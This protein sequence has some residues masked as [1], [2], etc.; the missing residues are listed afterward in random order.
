MVVP[1]SEVVH[2]YG[3]DDAKAFDIML[4]RIEEVT[5]TELVPI[6]LNSDDGIPTVGQN[7]T[8]VGFRAV[9]EDLT[10]YPTILHWVTV[11]YLSMPFCKNA[12]S[13]FIR[14][15]AHI[16][17]GGYH[18]GGRDSCCKGDSGGPL[19]ETLQVLRW[20]FRAS[21]LSVVERNRWGYM[22]AY[23]FLLNGNDTILALDGSCR[24]NAK[25][26]A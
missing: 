2:P 24:V 15:I 20:E 19:L 17:A 18:Q 4:F 26:I 1:G 5:E 21:G 6:E 16:C 7:S 25:V 9:N 10:D 23:Q 8:T 11:E 14:I 13:G 22:L 3:A 12:Y